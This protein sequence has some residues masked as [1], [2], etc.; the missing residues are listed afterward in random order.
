M[1]Q[2]DAVLV[3]N[4]N[5]QPELCVELA[6]AI[7]TDVVIHVELIENNT[8]TVITNGF[9]SGQIQPLKRGDW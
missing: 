8:N 4:Y 5:V 9:K 6:E 7:E 2:P 3:A 1:E